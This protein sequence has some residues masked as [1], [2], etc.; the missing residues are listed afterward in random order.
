[1]SEEFKIMFEYLYRCMNRDI[2][3]NQCINN[4]VVAVNTVV[5]ADRTTTS[6]SLHP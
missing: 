1:M 3:R 6:S 2:K 4:C 5:A